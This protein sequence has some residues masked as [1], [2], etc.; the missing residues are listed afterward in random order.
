MFFLPYLFYAPT[1][2]WFFLPS[3]FL[4]QLLICTYFLFVD[5]SRSKIN[6]IN[7]FKDVRG[8]CFL[9]EKR[10]YK[11]LSFK[12]ILLQLIPFYL[13]EVQRLQGIRLQPWWCSLLDLACW[14]WVLGCLMDLISLLLRSK[15]FFIYLLCFYWFKYFIILIHFQ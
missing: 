14:L 1:R 15:I 6:S 2:A 8:K 9:Q 10:Q 13:G 7:L 3:H 4:S 5:S 11:S 12:Q